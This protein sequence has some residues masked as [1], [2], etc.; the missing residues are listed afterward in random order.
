LCLIVFESDQKVFSAG[1]DV[2]EHLPERAPEMIKAFHKL[3]IAMLNLE[4][5]TLALVKSAC[6]GGG[7][8]FALFCDFIIAS[9]TASFAQ[10]EIKL[11]FFPP[12]SMAHLVYLTG[13]KKALELILTGE[14][15]TAQEALQAGLVNHVFPEEEFDQKAEKFIN[16]IVQ[17]SPSIIRTTLKKFFLKNC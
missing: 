5:P 11:A 13:N 4:I 7:S 6:L 3:F 1:V 10:P 16:S 17:N 8:E 15:V 9:E 2:A 14:K 12:L